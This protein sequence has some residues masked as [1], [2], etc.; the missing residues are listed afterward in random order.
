[1]REATMIEKKF[2]FQRAALVRPV[3]RRASDGLHVEMKG[4]R[5]AHVGGGVFK[6]ERE[7]GAPIVVRSVV[8]AQVLSPWSEETVKGIA[9]VC[10]VH[11]FSCPGDEDDDCACEEQLVP[12]RRWWCYV[13]LVRGACEVVVVRRPKMKTLADRAMKSRRAFG[14]GFAVMITTW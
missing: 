2:V 12:V 9:S 6:V 3:G 5:V 11:G 4:L 7:D 10:T 13:Q 14:P 8:Q 1:M